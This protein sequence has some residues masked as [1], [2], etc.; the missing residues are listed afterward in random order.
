MIL[1]FIKNNDLRN[2]RLLGHVDYND[3]KRYLQAVDI[4]VLPT[5]QDLNS[6]SV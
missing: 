1:L 5:L 3:I 2:T 4:F 6:L